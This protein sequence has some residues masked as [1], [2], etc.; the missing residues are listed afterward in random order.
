MF[1][2][3]FL[4]WI[5]KRDT[6]SLIEKKRKKKKKF[7][8]GHFLKLHTYIMAFS[9]DDCSH[10]F[11]FPGA[12]QDHQRATQHCFC[13]RCD[14]FFNTTQQYENHRHSLHN[15]RCPDCDKRFDLQHFLEQH[16]QSTGHS[17]CRL[18][19]RY[20]ACKGAVDNHRRALHEFKCDKC[21]KVFRTEEAEAAHRRI[22]RHWFGASRHLRGR[23]VWRRGKSIGYTVGGSNEYSGSCYKFGGFLGGEFWCGRTILNMLLGH[24]R[25]WL[26]AINGFWF[27]FGMRSTQATHLFQRVGF[28]VV[29]DYNI[30]AGRKVFW[31]AAVIVVAIIILMVAMKIAPVLV[32]GIIRWHILL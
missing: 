5:V 4:F 31:G 7:E 14:R 28:L 6:E 25:R 21:A 22:K 17:Y 18:C 9:C 8:N 27:I 19:A 15:F 26:E 13:R 16:Q 11:P 20:F 12:L 3:F 10:H 29:A 32:A 24:F 23:S 30:V 1:C 2:I